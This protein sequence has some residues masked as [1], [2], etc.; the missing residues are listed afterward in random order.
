M[1]PVDRDEL[2]AVWGNRWHLLAEGKTTIAPNIIRICSARSLVAFRPA[3]ILL[4]PMLVAGGL[5]RGL[6]FLLTHVSLITV[7]LILG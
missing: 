5:L 7:A 4:S 2:T 3:A 6:G 1:R